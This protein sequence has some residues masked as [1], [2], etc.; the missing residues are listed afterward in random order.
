MSRAA[1]LVP[2]DL[3]NLV[4]LEAIDREIERFDR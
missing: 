4:R 3:R 2:N 1:I